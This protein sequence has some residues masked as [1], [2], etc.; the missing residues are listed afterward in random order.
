MEREEPIARNEVDHETPTKPDGK[1]LFF[2]YISEESYITKSTSSL[3]L[4]IV[5][6]PPLH[7]LPVGLRKR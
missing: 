6:N 3:C 2:F 7:H 1:V 5:Q 4:F